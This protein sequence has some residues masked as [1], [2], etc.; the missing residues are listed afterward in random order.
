MRSR[1]SLRT[2]SPVTMPLPAPPSSAVRIGGCC[3]SAS[4]GPAAVSPPGYWTGRPSASAAIDGGA[5]NVRVRSDGQRRCGM[6]AFEP[7]DLI[8]IV[9]PCEEISALCRAEVDT[10]SA[11]VAAGACFATDAPWSLNLDRLALTG[12]SCPAR[13]QTGRCSGNHDFV[14]NLAVCAFRLRQS[15]TPGL[16]STVARRGGA[17]ARV[18]RPGRSRRPAGRGLEADRYRDHGRGVARH[19]LGAGARAGLVGTAR[20]DH[21]RV[22]RGDRL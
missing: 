19:D 14:T 3:M 1:T 5:G 18:P 7:M 9:K 6:A 16:A 8:L 15:G 20:R 13:N 11:V 10:F 12:P 4:P 22:R 21:R 17:H 2:C